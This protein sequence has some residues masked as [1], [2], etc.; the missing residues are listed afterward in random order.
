M[1]VRL[2]GEM[3]KGVPDG[4]LVMDDSTYAVDLLRAD[5]SYAQLVAPASPHWITDV[6][7]DRADG[8]AITW[9][10]SDSSQGQYINEIIWTSPYS[11]VATGVQRR[12]VAVMTNDTLH[13]GGVRHAADDGTVVAGGHEHLWRYVPV[14][15]SCSVGVRE[16]ERKLR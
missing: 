11:A 4:A 7:V 5:G 10:E 15:R 6:A 12:E 9:I 14:R 8:N 3:P 13:L 1:P 16:A 2:P